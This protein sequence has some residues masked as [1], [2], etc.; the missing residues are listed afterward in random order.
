MENK[1][2]II[3]YKVTGMRTYNLPIITIL[4][5]S[6]INITIKFPDIDEINIKTNQKS[7][8]KQSACEPYPSMILLINDEIISTKKCFYDNGKIIITGNFTHI[9]STEIFNDTY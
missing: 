1:T 3:D 6:N 5:S 9:E 8:I 4:P 7:I 2:V